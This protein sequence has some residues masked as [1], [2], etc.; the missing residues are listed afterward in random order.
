IGS[1]KIG[2]HHRNKIG[3]VL[4]I[5][6]F[7]GLDSRDFGNGVG[8]VGIF[9]RVGEQILL[10]HGLRGVFGINAGAAQKQKL[11]HAVLIAL[12]DDIVLYHQVFVDEIGAIDIIGH[13]T[14][15]FGRSQKYVLRPFLFKELRNSHGIGEVELGVGTGDE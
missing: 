15:H 11:L 13:D 1:V 6:A 7:A 5:I 3:A 12:M 14:A 8:L 10:L 9:E 2:G 4:Q